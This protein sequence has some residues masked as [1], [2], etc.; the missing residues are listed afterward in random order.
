[1]SKK[2]KKIEGLELHKQLLHEKE[3]KRKEKRQMPLL[4]KHGKGK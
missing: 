4:A 2:A 3:Q 1:L